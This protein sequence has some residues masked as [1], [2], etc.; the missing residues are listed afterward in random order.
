[1]RRGNSRRQGKKMVPETC[2]ATGAV[3]YLK[4]G[5]NRLMHNKKTIVL[6]RSYTRH[7]ELSKR[8]FLAHF[9]LQTAQNG[10]VEK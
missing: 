5:C 6:T 7:L 8:H 9:H 3:F 2:D 1:M 10:T 4:M